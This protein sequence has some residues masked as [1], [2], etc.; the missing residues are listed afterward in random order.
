MLCLRNARWTILSISD[1]VNNHICTRLGAWYML[2]VQLPPS[3]KNAR[4]T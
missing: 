3:L 4:G 1:F 2:Y